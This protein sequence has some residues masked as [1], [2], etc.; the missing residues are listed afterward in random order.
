ISDLIRNDFAIEDIEVRVLPIQSVGVQGDERTYRHPVA[1][2]TSLRDWK[3]FEKIS[4]AITNRFTD[5]NRVML[6]LKGDV[7]DFNIKKS[8][9]N[10]KRVELLQKVDDT[11]NKIMVKAPENYGIWQF[12]VV[13]IPTSTKAESESIVLRPIV[14]TEAMT[15]SFAEIDWKVVDEL[16]EQISGDN[17]SHI[18]YDL[19]HKPPGTIEWE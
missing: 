19:T 2:F 11:V 10:A 9:I 4:T 7:G 17:I 15:A 16:V 18:F 1:L 6:V 14:S 5:V 12:P 8:D 13:L 3:Q